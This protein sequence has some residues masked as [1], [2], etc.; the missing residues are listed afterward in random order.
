[1]SDFMQELYQWSTG[2]IAPAMS[3]SANPPLAASSTSYDEMPDTPINHVALYEAGGSTLPEVPQ[4]IQ[5]VRVVARGV[6]RDAVKALI[7]QAYALY[8][9]AEGSVLVE[10]DLTD[11]HVHTLVARSRPQRAGNDENNYPLMSF[12]ME[13]RIRSTS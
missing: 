12:D 8:H 3:A 1:M 9:V 11:F 10:Q 13:A 7:D 4:S 2:T 5:M 6:D